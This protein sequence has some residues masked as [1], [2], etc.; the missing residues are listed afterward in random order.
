[1]QFGGKIIAEV[2]RPRAFVSEQFP[3][4]FHGLGRDAVKVREVDYLLQQRRYSPLECVGEAQ[5]QLRKHCVGGSIEQQAEMF[6]KARM[7]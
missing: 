7:E 5:M 4:A 6:F 2:S 1:M 3:E